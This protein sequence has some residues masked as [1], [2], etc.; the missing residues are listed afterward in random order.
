MLYAILYFGESIILYIFFSWIWI[1]V[2][3]HVVACLSSDGWWRNLYHC[4]DSKAHGAN[5]GPTWVLSAPGGP[6]VGPRNLAIRVISIWRPFRHFIP[7]FYPQIVSRASSVLVVCGGVTARVMPVTALMAA[8]SPSV[9]MAGSGRA[10][11]DVSFRT[12]RAKA[13][14]SV[15]YFPYN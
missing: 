11:N 13:E 8:V 5:M 3:D 9:K 1:D 2:D 14:K 6:H 15:K 4:P 12:P 10:A 7:H